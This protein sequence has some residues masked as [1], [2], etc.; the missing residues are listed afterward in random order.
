M[1]TIIRTIAFTTLAALLS[2]ST[3][4]YAQT[5]SGQ[6]DGSNAKNLLVS[7]IDF[8]NDVLVPFIFALAFIVFL[9]GIFNYFVAGG[10]DEEKREKGKKF[11]VWGILAFF[12]MVSVWG[13]VNLL[14]GTIGFGPNG[15]RNPDLPKFQTGSSG[16]ATVEP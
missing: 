4:S 7:I 3:V 1:K 13:I 16:G 14:V 9:W 15:D 11:A 2:F 5:G 10:A 12:I 8:I 6:L